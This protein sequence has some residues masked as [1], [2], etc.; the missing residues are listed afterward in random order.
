MQFGC[1]QLINRS[2][3]RKPL[4]HA[5][6]ILILNYIQ[7]LFKRVLFYKYVQNILLFIIKQYI[8][9]QSR[10]LGFFFL[11]LSYKHSDIFCVLFLFLLINKNLAPFTA[12]KDPFLTNGCRH[13][14]QFKYTYPRNPFKFGFIYFKTSVFFVHFYY[15]NFE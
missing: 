3:L 7:V 10:R 13:Y 1:A 8:A 6:Y 4:T 15:L 9:F 14:L 11:F 5:D 12:Y 2:H